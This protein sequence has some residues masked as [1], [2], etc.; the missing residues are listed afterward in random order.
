MS[1][2]GAITVDDPEGLQKRLKALEKEWP[3][4]MDRMLAE[5]AGKLA[6]MAAERTPPL[7]AG[8]RRGWKT[9]VVKRGGAQMSVDVYHPDPAAAKLE[10]GSRDSGVRQQGRFMLALALSRLER[11]WPATLGQALDA[12][13]SGEG[14]AGRG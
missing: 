12:V 3:A 14:G 8:S 11:E 2:M 10:Y 5:E 13:L 6:D 4:L 1:A 9:G 7:W